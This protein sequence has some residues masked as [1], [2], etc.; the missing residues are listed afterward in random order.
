MKRKGMSCWRIADQCVHRDLWP[1]G[2]WLSVQVAKLAAAWLVWGWRKPFCCGQQT[3]HPSHP[4][5]LL[6]SCRYITLPTAKEPCCHKSG[7]EVRGRATHWH[8]EVR[9]AEKEE[10]G[11]GEIYQIAAQRAWGNSEECAGTKAS[12]AQVVLLGRE[13]NTG[14]GL[15]YGEREPKQSRR[16]ATSSWASGATQRRSGWVFG[17]G[18]V[19]Q[20]WEC[21]SERHWKGQYGCG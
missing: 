14:D 13:R 11:G 5:P 12:S 16:R 2:S 9:Q 15:I 18:N 6:F 19:E 17:F 4:P 21:G 1:N 3:S 7:G 8:G 20:G 10:G